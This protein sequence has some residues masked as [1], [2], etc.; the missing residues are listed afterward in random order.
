MSKLFAGYRDKLFEDFLALR[1]R[2]FANKS[3]GL[4]LWQKLFTLP[5]RKKQFSCEHGAHIKAA[6]EYDSK[7]RQLLVIQLVDGH[8]ET[9]LS[10]FVVRKQEL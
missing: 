10:S 2:C 5:K 4:R 3:Y 9:V 7:S 8:F 6:M 1:D